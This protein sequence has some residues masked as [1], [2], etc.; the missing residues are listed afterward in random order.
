VRTATD[1]YRQDMD[2]VGQWIEERCV[3]HPDANTPSK[4]AY[5]DYKFWAEE[6]IGWALS[7]VRWRR[8]LSEHGFKAAKGTHGERIT[9]GLRLKFDPA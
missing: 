4:A 7:R 3:R 9:K 2:V 6:E 5:G 8:N 1:E